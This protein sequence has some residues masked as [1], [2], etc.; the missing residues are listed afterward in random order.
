MYRVLNK[1]ISYGKESKT[2]LRIL[3]FCINSILSTGIFHGDDQCFAIAAQACGVWC[4]GWTSCL[5]C[6]PNLWKFEMIVGLQLLRDGIRFFMPLLCCTF[7]LIICMVESVYITYF[8]CLIFNPWTVFVHKP[9]GSFQYKDIVVPDYGLQLQKL[10]RSHG[11][12]I[13][14]MKFHSWKDRLYI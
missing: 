13:L 8:V 12:L 10:W 9:C 4:L 11:P 3:P 1:R 5:L 2:S 7:I 6:W 14:I